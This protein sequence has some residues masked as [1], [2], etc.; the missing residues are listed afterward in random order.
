MNQ[1]PS[2][3][4]QCKLKSDEELKEI[5]NSNDYEDYAKDIAKEILNSDRKEYHQYQSSINKKE[6]AEEQKINAQKTDPLYDDIHQIAKDLR[7]I[8]N[9]FIIGIAITA[10]LIIIGFLLK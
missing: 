6:Q 7:F 5:I 10:I 9:L 1:H 3:C 8:K 2:L 4:E